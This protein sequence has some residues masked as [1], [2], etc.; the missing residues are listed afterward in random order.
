[1]EQGI[2]FEGVN[3]HLYWHDF[4][5]LDFDMVVEHYG[6][7]GKPLHLTLHLPLAGG[8]PSAVQAEWLQRVWLVAMSKPFVVGVQVALDA[9]APATLQQ[10]R[11]WRQMWKQSAPS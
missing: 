3:L 8:E 7:L 5:L 6:D 9:L 11:A 1:V 2:P 10:L 4:D